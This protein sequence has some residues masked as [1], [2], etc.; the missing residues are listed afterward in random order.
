[1]KKIAAAFLLCA[2][3]ALGQGNRVA[4]PTL[5]FVP[6]ASGGGVQ[7]I[8]GIAG[9]ARLGHAIPASEVSNLAVAPGGH[10]LLAEQNGGISVAALGNA[11]ETEI[12][13]A[14]VSGA[15]A[16][17]AKFVFSP[18]GS[19]AA[20]YSPGLNT[21]QVITGL[22]GAPQTGTKFE[23]VFALKHI[24]ISDDGQEL[25]VQQADGLLL[26]A[27][28]DD[29]LLKSDSLGA[30]AFAPSSHTA[31]I[32]DNAAQTLVLA[33]GASVSTIH[34]SDPAVMASAQ[35]LVATF[36]GSTVIAGSPSAHT[37]WSIDTSTGKFKKYAVEDAVLS[38]T[39]LNVKDTFLMQYSGGNY[40][41]ATWRNGH[42][43]ISFVGVVRDGGVQ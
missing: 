20:I 34:V 22:P 17:A 16:Q 41:V 26:N 24:A 1:M 42:L 36:D 4:V 40:G 39:P 30:I 25:L 37:V 14:P 8:I 31:F 2:V 23:T 27:G 15:L 12:S 6:A 9:A 38:F 7:P 19:A 43:S 3:S 35:S 29:T 18:S 5:G 33:S 10:Y 28:T 11:A 13:F 21:V 32:A